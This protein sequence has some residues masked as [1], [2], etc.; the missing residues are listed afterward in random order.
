MTEQSSQQAVV[1]DKSVF[2]NLHC[3]ARMTV[4]LFAIAYDGAIDRRKLTVAR[5]V[6]QPHG[7]AE[8]CRKLHA[9]RQAQVQ[10]RGAD[11][12]QDTVETERLIVAV[13]APNSG[14]HFVL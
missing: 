9:S 4:V 7:N 1:L 12:V 8:R 3:D 6:R 2:D 11:V 5:T 10:T 13:H 14:H